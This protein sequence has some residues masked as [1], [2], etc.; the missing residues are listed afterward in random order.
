MKLY[1]NLVVII[2]VIL[3]NSIY[4][5]DYNIESNNGSVIST[6]SAT[7]YDSG[8]DTSN[9][10]S[11][12]NLL[13]TFNSSD[14]SC[15]KL[16]FL[17]LNLED[18]YDVIYI[19]DGDST[20]TD[21][22]AVIT[23]STLPADIYTSSS[24]VTIRMVTDGSVVRE[25]FI[26][27]VSCTSDCYVPSPPPI[28]DEPCSAIELMVNDSC[29]SQ[30]YSN[31]GATSTTIS[32]PDC[33]LSNY[34]GNDVWF[35]VQVPSSGIL[36][37]KTLSGSLNSGG[38]ALYKGSCDSLIILSC[39][40]SLQNLDLT[41]IINSSDNL[42]NQNIWIRIWSINDNL[43]GNFGICAYESDSESIVEV[44]TNVYSAQYLVNN[45]LVSGCLNTFNI[46]YE[47]ANSAISYFDGAYTILGFN[48]GI[49]LSTGNVLNVSGDG[50][51]SDPGFSTTNNNIASDLLQL[52]QE[53]AGTFSVYD[54]V[55]LEF[56]FIPT[57]DVIEF[58]YIFASNEYPDYNCSVYND[59]FGFFVSGSG[60][61]GTYSD[62][63]VNI[64]LIPGT[65]T[66][67]CI[68]N[69]HDD[70]GNSTWNVCPAINSDLYINNDPSY[71]PTTDAFLYRGYTVPLTAK[72]NVQACQTYHIKLAI[73][74]GGDGSL[75]SGV[76]LEAESFTSGDV[77]ICNN[78]PLFSCMENQ[79]VEPNLGDSSYIVNGTEFDPNTYDINCDEI[80]FNNDFNNSN[81]LESAVFPY[82][83][84]TVVW[85]FS[86]LAG[87][88]SE[89][90]FDVNVGPDVNLVNQISNDFL[91]YP[92][93]NNG[94]FEIKFGLIK[95]KTEL[96]ILDIRGKIVYQKE[97]D[98]LDSFQHK[99][100][101]LS[102][103]ENGLYLLK[104]SSKDELM[105]SK[106]IKL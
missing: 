16:S 34:G 18:G 27:Q 99:N 37:I 77:V 106:I 92:N 54:V 19:Y 66:P 21:I 41:E 85:S 26:V 79:I 56:D 45:V 59:V 33:S 32:I 20:S 83:V 48:S 80:T 7:L 22:L 52:A 24:Y 97:F 71:V 93:P 57:S 98:K 64:A 102:N 75:D 43:E 39:R 47:G 36:T 68:A 12:E 9:Y 38:I 81:S 96:K 78:L 10:G 53:N 28:N 51:A 29:F 95:S 76:F 50:M 25:G 88:N 103:F 40:E 14:G 105:T 23:G 100:I 46:E 55:I 8:G 101:D 58:R 2:L 44:F 62:N 72:L 35:L 42:A 70:T 61:S 60:I 5:T 31:I 82:G 65:N 17:S 74:D 63:A 91:L 11:N 3:S 89:C 6:C 69:I 30:V 73:A 104:F 84:T 49:F 86:D 15:F 94:I 4:A 13:T 67:V 1:N 87:N 90:S